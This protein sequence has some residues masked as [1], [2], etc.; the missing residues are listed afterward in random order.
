[1]VGSTL[2]MFRLPPQQKTTI[3][4]LLLPPLLFLS[5]VLLPFFLSSVAT[6][7]RRSFKN[8]RP[9]SVRVLPF[10]ANFSA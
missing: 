2:V 5:S 9:M 10:P 3:P 1:M 4:Q 8:A 7:M 6:I